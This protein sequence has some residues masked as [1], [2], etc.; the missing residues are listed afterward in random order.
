M[1][2]ARMLAPHLTERWKQPVTSTV[3]LAVR[4]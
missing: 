2:A 3:G 1:L 4:G